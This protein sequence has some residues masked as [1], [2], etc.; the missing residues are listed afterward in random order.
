MSDLDRARK[1]YQKDFLGYLAV[2]RNLAPRTLKEYGDDL[3]LFFEYFTPYL[4][5]G[6]T[7]QTM[8]ERTIRDFLTWLK[9]ERRYSAR[10]LN[11]K[12]ACLKNYFKYLEKEGVVPKSPVADVKTLKLPRHLPKV[13]SQDEVAQVLEPPPRP[14][15]PRR[16]RKGSPQMQQFT[17]ARD[18]A[19]MELFY[20]T[21]M[22][23]SEMVG[24]ELADI[25]LREKVIRVTGKGN[26]QR[27]VLM[28]EA[29]AEALTT[30]L[31]C[32]LKTDAR[33][34]FINRRGVRLSIRAVEYMFE[35]RL[36]Q[37]DIRKKASP[38]TMRH[39]FATHLLE[40][41]SD[42]MTIKELLGHESLATTQIY[43]HVSMARMKEVY[44][45]AHPRE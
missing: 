7:L 36:R 24:L 23:V 9:V 14:D 11:R 40:G 25:D 6:L 34:V 37:A 41:G 32:R 28:N 19:I 2:E 13:L 12:L 43:S 39:S 8:D 42:L 26:K 29:A 5:D 33:A 17:E 10:A 21:G 1:Y 3:R 35:D 15:R 27:M 31:A 30:Y 44:R 18:R 20:A 4:D 16:A 45:S 22:R 38:H